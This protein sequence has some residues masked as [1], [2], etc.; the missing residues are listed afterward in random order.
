MYSCRSGAFHTQNGGA[1]LATGVTSW[2]PRIAQRSFLDTPYQERQR[3]SARAYHACSVSRLHHRLSGLPV[4]PL[5]CSG[6]SSGG[7]SRRRRRPPAA[8]ARRPSRGSGQFVRTSTAEWSPRRRRSSHCVAVVGHAGRRALQHQRQSFLL[9]GAQ[10]LVGPAVPL[11][12]LAR[13][14]WRC[15]GR[16][17]DDRRYRP[18]RPAASDRIG[19]G[20][21]W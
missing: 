15:P 14:F 1:S 9:V 18:R 8:D 10:A 13:R 4:V 19:G 20:M 17:R 12:R 16:R 7:C 2:P 6:T 11:E 21:R 5:V 3:A